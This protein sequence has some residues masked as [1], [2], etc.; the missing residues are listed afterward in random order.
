[1]NNS[2]FFK[3]IARLRTESEEENMDNTHLSKKEIKV[4]LKR[5]LLG[6]SLDKLKEKL[7]K[8]TDG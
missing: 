1:M 2:F 7:E 5:E 3:D 8:V 4:L 6:V